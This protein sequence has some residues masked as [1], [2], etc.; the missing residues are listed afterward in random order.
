MKLH[1]PSL[2][3]RTSTA[4]T[5]LTVYPPP[6]TP[7]Q[8]T[9]TPGFPST[10][11]FAGTE[12]ASLH[13]HH[14]PRAAAFV[15]V[16]LENTLVLLRLLSPTVFCVEVWQLSET[17]EDLPVAPNTI[18]ED[19]GRVEPYVSA[20]QISH[21][22]ALMAAAQKIFRPFHC[23][24]YEKEAEKEIEKGKSPE[25]SGQRQIPFEQAVGN[26][27]QLFN[28]PGHGPFLQEWRNGLSGNPGKTTRRRSKTSWLQSELRKNSESY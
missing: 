27:R 8:N 6:K 2:N 23:L 11:Q 18:C 22:M 21:R 28:F 5:K 3:P 15:L 26:T 9:Y 10:I 19:F 25:S 4:P 16:F 1:A 12:C 14:R 13:R 7:V 17:A 24:F 20:L